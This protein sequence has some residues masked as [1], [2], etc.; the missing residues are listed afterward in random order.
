[1]YT[2]ELGFYVRSLGDCRLGAM[3][4][5]RI[6]SVDFCEIFW[7]I[8]G[9]G[10]FRN[11][12]KKDFILRPGWVWY[13]PPGSLHVYRPDHCAFHYRWLTIAGPDA[14]K[15][16]AALKI[17]PGMHCAG[18]CPEQLFDNIYHKITA[19]ESQLEVLNNAFHILTRIVGGNNGSSRSGDD[20]IAETIKSM[21][22]NTFTDQNFSIATIAEHLGIHRTTVNRNFKTMYKI[23]VSNYLKSCRCQHALRLI[24]STRLP[25]VE[26]AHRSGFSSSNYFIR[27]IRQITGSTPG[28]LRGSRNLQKSDPTVQQNSHKIQQKYDCQV[29]LPDIY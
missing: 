17:T 12:N 26:I 21:I 8:D 25:I 7:A 3:E 5:Q 10:V 24:H 15:L 13:Y 27:S 22:D 20:N 29:Y 6:K 14:G 1:M 28:Q 11:E 4:R 9:R 2:G 23:D 18:S 16:F 19:P